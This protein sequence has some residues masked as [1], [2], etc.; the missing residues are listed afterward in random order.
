MERP[1]R[2]SAR[3]NDV[4]ACKTR[5]RMAGT[6]IGLLIHCNRPLLG[7][8]ASRHRRGPEGSAS[9]PQPG[10]QDDPR[11]GHR[12]LPAGRGTYGHP[13][14]SIYQTDII[15]YGT[16]LA[17]YI[18]CEFDRPTFLA[19]GGVRRA[20]YLGYLNLADSWANHPS[21][22]EGTPE[23][24]EYAL[25]ERGRELSDLASRRRAGKLR[26]TICVHTAA[27]L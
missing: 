21:W 2:A 8:A 6:G 3:T 27:V 11:L 25:F 1:Q 16:D 24:V 19:S 22:P 26:P 12:Y 20:D 15:V 17:D 5:R 13:V 23:L 10:T 4:D 9:A 7:P 18:S 14:L